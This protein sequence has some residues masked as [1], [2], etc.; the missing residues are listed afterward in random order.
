MALFRLAVLILI[1]TLLNSNSE[2]LDNLAICFF[3]NRH[4]VFFEK[5]HMPVFFQ[6]LLSLSIKRNFPANLLILAINS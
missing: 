2:Q 4:M 6:K 3:N 5:Y 1:L